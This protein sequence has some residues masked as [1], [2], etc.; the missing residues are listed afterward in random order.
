MLYLKIFTQTP[1]CSHTYTHCLNWMNN[2]YFIP[3]DIYAHMHAFT[4]THA[5][6]TMHKHKYAHVC[7]CIH[8]H[9][10]GHVDKQE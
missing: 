2:Q 9:K 8:T 4:H 6:S 10:N 7:T 3:N 5:H 1:M